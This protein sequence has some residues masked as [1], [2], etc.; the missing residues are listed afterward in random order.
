MS[1]KFWTGVVGAPVLLLLMYVGGW[2]F[3]LAMT[4]AMLLGLQE[5][6]RN[7]QRKGIYAF[8]PAGWLCGTGIFAATWFVTWDAAWR[9]GIIMAC[10]A[11]AVL[12]GMIAQLWRPRGTSVIANSGATVFGVVWVSLLFSFM[13]RLRL[14]ELSAI[15]DVPE[16]GFR[17]R[18]GILF[19]TILIVWLQD[20][21]AQ[22]TGRAFGKRKPWPHIS[23]N[24]TW[25]GCIGGFCAALIASGVGGTLFGLPTFEM[26]GLGAVLGVLG[27][28]GDFCKSLIK[29]ELGIKDF[30]AI[31]P[32]HGGVLDRFDSLL[33]SM[34][35]AYLY[36]RLFLLLHAMPM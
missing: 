23:P 5:F 1:S 36:F 24:K 32:G 11:G 18:T 35:L 26:I 29:R 13:L 10:I 7:I 16:G 19:L 12:L 25:E 3:F 27:Q 20:N 6:Y 17:D 9:S 2:P 4:A 21:A 22:L 14:L 28:L 30:G 8:E 33:F 34:P 31:L 15:S